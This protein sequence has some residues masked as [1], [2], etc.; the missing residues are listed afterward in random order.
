MKKGGMHHFAREAGIKIKS[1]VMR[2]GGVFVV[3]KG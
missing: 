2:G 3:V 1:E